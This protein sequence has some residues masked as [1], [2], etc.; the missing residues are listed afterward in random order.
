MNITVTGM[1]GRRSGK[2]QLIEAA[3]FFAAQ[4]MDPRMVR[5]LT[6]DIEVRRGLDVDGECVDEDGVR[7]PRWFTIGLKNQDIDEMIKV[8]AHEMVH[9]KQHAKNELQSG[10]MVA[11]RGG[12]KMSSRWMGEIW[13][14]E[15]KEC[16]YYDS[17]WEIEAYGREVGLY[18]KWLAAQEAA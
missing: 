14:P 7:N 4:L 8:L 18:Q 9:V 15:G 5:N 17:P 16:H 11:T 13:K 3:K 1:V 12:M 2:L 10:L 6:V